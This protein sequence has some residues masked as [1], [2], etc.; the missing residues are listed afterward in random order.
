[1]DRISAL[2]GFECASACLHVY[3]FADELLT[4]LDEEEE[5][6]KENKRKRKRRRRRRR[7]AH[8]KGTPRRTNK[9]LTQERL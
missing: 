1:M 2:C 3:V 7:G 8:S 5:E 6:E 9:T 4:A